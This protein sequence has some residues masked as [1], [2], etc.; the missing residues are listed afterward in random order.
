M[1]KP[2]LV[3]LAA[4]MGSRYGGLKQIDKIGP[5]GE[6]IIELSIYDAI[7]AGFGKIVFI[8]KHEIEADFKEAIGNKISKVID[9]EYVYQDLTN[10]PEG[11][12]IP[13]GRVKPWGTAQALLC[14]K[15]VLDGPFAVINSDDYYGQACFKTLYDFL[16]TNTDEN[17]Y[18]MV[19]YV[20]ENTVTEAGSVARGCCVV[21]DGKLAN[22]IERTKIEKHENG[23]QYLENDEWHDID[24]K[25]LVSMNMWAFNPSILKH[26]EKMFP[27][28]LKNTVPSNP[29]KSEC[30]IPGIV[31]ELLT[32]GIVNVKMMSSTDKW[33][34]VTY[35]ED[36]PKVKAGIAKLINDGCYPKDLFK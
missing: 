27:E 29:L 34:G 28:F 7:K 3:I 23:I 8:I 33:Y 2:T 14:C 10:I 32:K 17:Q 21:K 16:T 18:G 36:K 24:A 26:I 11:F 12:S 15:D 5:N 25:T 13:E 31:G 35:Q 6:I 1:N 4:G 9:V 19:G 20:L 30:F 22:V